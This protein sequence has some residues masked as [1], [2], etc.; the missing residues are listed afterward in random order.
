MQLE[1][2]VGVSLL[3]LGGACDRSPFLFSFF[4]SSFLFFI[5]N[6]DEATLYSWNQLS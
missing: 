2:Q 4:F 1:V 6:M 5:I 3:I